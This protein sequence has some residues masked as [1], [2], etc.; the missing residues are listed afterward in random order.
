MTDWTLSQRFDSPEGRICWDVFGDGPPLVLLHGT[1]N[2]SFI[3]RNVV[4]A[5]AGQYSVYVFDW[6]GFGR[7][8]RYA[9][10]N[11][12]WDEQP[13]RLVELIAH[14]GLD[15]P[16]I[17][18]FDFAPIFL[19]RAH[20]L[21]GLR[22][23]PTVLTDAAV[24]PPFLTDFS[25]QVRET[26]SV[27]RLLPTHI[28]EGAI[29]AHLRTATHHRMRQ[30]VLDAYMAP[31]RGEEGVAAYWRAV[32][33]YD[34]AMAQPLTGRLARFKPPALVLWGEH[35]AWLPLS[36]GH[37]L[38]EA[39]PGARFETVAGAGHF[40]PEDNPEGVA[41]AISA[42]LESAGYGEPGRDGISGGQRAGI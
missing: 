34:E 21:E 26:I 3:W 22:L 20:F 28:A 29:A 8:D 40:A 15:S 27:F 31:W 1:P 25:R 37:A 23:G 17:V 32:S 11:V 6:P 39:I 35:D 18:A 13:R 19:L 5:L 41:Q 7:S 10:Q 24:I 2:W 36:M 30:E 14:W 12:S 42:F 9:D 38:A 33:N 4:H 16:A